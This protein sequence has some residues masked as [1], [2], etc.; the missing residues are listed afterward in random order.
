MGFHFTDL[1][2]WSCRD[3][4]SVLVSIIFLGGTNELLVIKEDMQNR[5]SCIFGRSTV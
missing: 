1:E 4:L 2:V 3:F 5:I